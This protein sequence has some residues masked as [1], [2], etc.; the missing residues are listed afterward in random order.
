MYTDN[1]EDV[2]DWLLIIMRQLPSLLVAIYL[3]LKSML[4]SGLNVKVKFL[5]HYGQYQ[6]LDLLSEAKGNYP[7]IWNEDEALLF[8]GFCL[9]GCNQGV[10]ADNFANSVNLL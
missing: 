9:S 8:Q 10:Y 3:A 6:G 2:V 4:R 1:C 7:Q 5:A